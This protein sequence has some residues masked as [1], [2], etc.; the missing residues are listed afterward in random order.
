MSCNTWLPDG[1]AQATQKA[2]DFLAAKA[3]DNDSKPSGQN[4]ITDGHDFSNEIDRL[5]IWE[6]EHDVR[7]GELDDKLRNASDLR[8]RVLSLLEQLAGKG[9]DITIEATL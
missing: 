1:I 7:S 2:I 9:H 5:N 3:S 4:P 6:A 8:G